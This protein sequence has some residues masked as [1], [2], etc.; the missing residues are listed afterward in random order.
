LE[1]DDADEEAEAKHGVLELESVDTE[2]ISP[3]CGSL[4]MCE[5]IVRCQIKFESL[6]L[7]PLYVY[8]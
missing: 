1:T 6:Q 2:H 5:S 8:L 4:Q 7:V 3:V